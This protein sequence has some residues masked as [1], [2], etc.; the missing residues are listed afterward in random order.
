MLVLTIA[1]LHLQAYWCE[2]KDVTQLDTL[3]EAVAPFG[4]MAAD[5]LES[6]SA[7]RILR[8][9]TSEAAQRGAFGVP[10]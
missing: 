2:Q 4:L 5:L 8:A 6:D 7:S 9:N 3:Q 10:R 1:C